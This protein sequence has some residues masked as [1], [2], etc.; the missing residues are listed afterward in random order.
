[1]ILLIA[2]SCALVGGGLLLHLAWT[3]RQALQVR[4]RAWSWSADQLQATLIRGLPKMLV[5]DR[6]HPAFLKTI[7]ADKVRTRMQ[8]GAYDG[9]NI[10]SPTNPVW[11]DLGLAESA[12]QAQVMLAC[13]QVLWASVFDHYYHLRQQDYHA[14]SLQEVPESDRHL[15]VTEGTLYA[16]LTTRALKIDLE[17]SDPRLEFYA[18]FMVRVRWSL[19][20]QTLETSD[21]LVFES[22]PNR[23]PN[24]RSLWAKRYH[25]FPERKYLWKKHE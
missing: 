24:P 19:L 11:S 17:E 13:T 7:L 14:F 22:G 16:M 25:L 23:P 12:V 9:F 18:V 4:E 21:V 1:M 3:R 10:P 5:W 8:I 2:S 6:S 20:K 15:Q